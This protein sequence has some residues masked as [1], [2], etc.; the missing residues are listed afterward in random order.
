M[1]NA[2][3]CQKVRYSAWIPAIVALLSWG[4]PATS[5]LAQD[6]SGVY[7]SG[8]KVLEVGDRLRV[9]DGLRGVVSEG[10]VVRLTE[11]S[12]FLEVKL[13]YSEWRFSM[14]QF[15]AGDLWL[16][17]QTGSKAGKW[18]LIGLVTGATVGG[19]VGYC[20]N[21]VS[22]VGGGSE[23]C[24]G[25]AHAAGMGLAY[26]G[27]GGL[28]LGLIT[29]A[30]SPRYEVIGFEGGEGRADLAVVPAIGPRGRPAVAVGLRFRR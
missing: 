18:G 3:Y 27:A 4:G 7:A 15:R 2:T 25:N 8:K 14:E 5:L 22:P 30:M 24:E 16:E 29:G 26:V 28:L 19:I 6:A 10:G 17:R 13:R 11:D 12:L 20:V 1:R 23:D 21:Q 9:T